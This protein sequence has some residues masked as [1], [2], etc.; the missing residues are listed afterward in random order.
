MVGHGF[1]RGLYFIHGVVEVRRDANP[2]KSTTH[3]STTQIVGFIHGLEDLS[4]TP[5]WKCEYYD[6]TRQVGR[7]RRM[8][9]HAWNGL[10]QTFLYGR[11]QG[12]D[13]CFD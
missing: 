12:R 13:P 1:H 5:A 11:S 2:V 6:P 10:G 7:S 8:E 3:G 9:T 4:V